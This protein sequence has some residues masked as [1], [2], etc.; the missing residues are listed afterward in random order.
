MQAFLFDFDGVIVDTERHWPAVNKQLFRQWVPDWSDAHV[1][2]IKGLSTEG[3]H[4]HIHE[5]YGVQIPFSGFLDTLQTV[6]PELYRTHC[7]LLPGVR[8]LIERLE[9]ARIKLSIASSSQRAWIDIALDRFALR[10]HFPVI[11]S[12]DNVPGRAKPYPDVYLL[13]AKE[14]GVDPHACIAIEDSD[15]GITAALSAGMRCIAFHTDM[16]AGQSLS[17]ADHHVHH[18]DEVTI[19]LLH[20]VMQSHLPIK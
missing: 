12:A 9:T 10:Q 1:Q 4:A 2:E 16:N 5:K 11:A 18:L 7:A 13:A 14:L 15:H 17:G 19:E 6:V 20:T 3:M 8:E